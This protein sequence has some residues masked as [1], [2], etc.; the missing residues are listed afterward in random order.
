MPE[1]NKSRVSGVGIGVAFPGLQQEPGK[2]L[3]SKARSL[4]YALYW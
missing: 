4:A 3:P 1:G 2:G